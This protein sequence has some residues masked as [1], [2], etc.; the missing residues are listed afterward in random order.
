MNKHNAN[1]SIK[2]IAKEACKINTPPVVS[3]P[4]NK[5]LIISP[6]S[7]NTSNTINKSSSLTTDSTFPRVLPLQ[8]K[9]PLKIKYRQV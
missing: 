1:N 6:N 5:N 9:E 4:S 7:N 3:S 2:V 8:P